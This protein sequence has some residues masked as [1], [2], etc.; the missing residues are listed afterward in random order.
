MKKLFVFF[1]LVIV[2]IS[3]IAQNP[4]YQQKLYY[5]CKAWGFMKYFHSNVSTCQ[6]NWD[7]VLMS[8]LPLIKRTSGGNDFNDALFRMLQAAGPMSIAPTSLKEDLSDNKINNLSID[9][10]KDDLLSEDVKSLL[11]FVSDNFRPH[12]I[13]WIKVAENPCITGYFDLPFDDPVFKRDLATDYPD[14]YGRL[15]GMFKYWNI[16]NY[17]NPNKDILETPWDKTLFDYVLPIANAANFMDFFQT[18]KKITSRLDDAHV[19]GLTTR[20]LSSYVP[21][22]LL[23]YVQGNYVVVKSGYPDIK[24]GDIIVSIDGKTMTQLEE[25]WRPAISAGNLNVFRRFMCSYILRG[26]MGAPIQIEYKDGLNHSNTSILYRYSSYNNDWFKG[27]NPSEEPVAEKWKKFNCNVG[28]V[29][30]GILELSD[31]ETMYNDLQNSSAIIFDIRNYPKG[32]A[33]GIA[34]LLYPYTVSYAKFIRPDIQHPGRYISN[35]CSFGASTSFKGKVIILCN[36]QTQSHAEYSCM[37]LRAVPNAL[38]VGSQTAGADGTV[39]WFKLSDNIQTGFTALG[40]TYPDGRE[41]QRIGIVP[42]IFVYPTVEGIRQ[43]RDEVLEKAM[44]IVCA[45]PIDKEENAITELTIYPNPATD[46]ISI[47][48]PNSELSNSLSI[49]NSIGIEV[50]RFD[51]NELLGQSTVSFST[52]FFSSGV[53][54]C[55]LNSG[56][57]KTSRRF[58]VAR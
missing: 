10:F 42:D 38:V 16:L 28:Y 30:M 51:K 40:V 56:T 49:Y 7:S 9:W 33:S 24:K 29:N 14:E 44:E 20:F 31:V 35:I 8:N 21:I 25:S 11:G 12:E 26:E 57:N 1:I 34:D 39:D 17:F 48:F 55:T 18:F 54:C 53:Y 37:I 4:T 19:E 3:A 32:T 23:R 6:V 36:E 47:S 41:T 15:T 58:V 52:E 43:G 22:I 50:M 27:Y 2:G 5:T 45:P 46:Q 13:C